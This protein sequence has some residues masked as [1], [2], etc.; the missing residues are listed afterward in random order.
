M[1]ARALRREIDG[2]LERGDRF[3]EILPLFLDHPE[4]PVR[5]RKV[6]VQLDGVIALF[7]RGLVVAPVGVDDGEIPRDDRRHR[8][9]RLREPHLF[10]RVVETAHR[11][12]ARHRVPV[13]GRRVRGIELDGDLELALRALPVPVLRGLDVRQRR[14][15]LRRVAVEHDRGRRARGGPASTPAPAAGRRSGPGDCARPP[16]RCA[17]ARTARLRRWPSRRSRAP[18]AALRRSA[19]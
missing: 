11:H 6:R 18:C 13:M 5:R 12:E 17:P 7:E 19:D 4:R 16:G 8:V 3:V 15:G 2:A 14:V 1:H 10:E 9:E